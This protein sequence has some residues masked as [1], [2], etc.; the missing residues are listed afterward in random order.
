MREER[1]RRNMGWRVMHHRLARGVDRRVQVP[2]FPGRQRQPI[3]RLRVLPI[4]TQR[5]PE[6]D[7]GLRG[8]AMLEEFRHAHRDIDGRGAGQLELCLHLCFQQR[9]LDDGARP[10]PALGAHHLAGSR[11]GG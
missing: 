8:L 9:P 4:D 3:P 6:P 10:L 1:G 7:I 2:L 11:R 5:P